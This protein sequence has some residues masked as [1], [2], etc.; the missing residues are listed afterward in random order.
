MCGI[1]GVI[2]FNREKISLN[3][4]NRFKDSLSHRGPDGEGT[5][6]NNIDCVAL[7]HRRLS[8]LDITESGK[9]PMSYDNERYWIVYNGE[10]YNFIELRKEL[11]S[12]GYAFKSNTDT[13]VILAAYIHWG[14]KCQYK[15]NGMWAFAI[16]DQVSKKIFI[17][18]DRFGVKPL[19]YS[20]SDKRIIFASELKAF[21]YLPKN[22]VPNFEL[23]SIASLGKSTNDEETFLENVNS[24]QPGGQIDLDIGG[25]YE[26]KKWWNTHDNLYSVS[27]NYESQIGTFRNLLRDAC[28]IRMRSDVPICSSLSGGMDSSS[29]VSMM[30]SIRK[31]Q[32]NDE[33]YNKNNHAA[34]ICDFIGSDDYEKYSERKYADEVVNFSNAEPFYINYDLKQVDQD[35][36]KKATFFQEMIG[37][38]A[39]GPWQIYKQMRKEKYYVSL[40]GH[41]GDEILAGYPTHI[42][43]AIEDA[44]S[45]N[46]DDYLKDILEIESYLTTVK[47]K[48]K[49]ISNLKLNYLAK[50]NFKYFDVIIKKIRDNKNKYWKKNSN[51]INVDNFQKIKF[52]KLDKKF[53]KFENFSILNNHLYHD[54]HKGV[55]TKVLHKFDRLSM[56]HGIEVRAPLLDYRIVQFLFSLPNT[57][58]ISNGYTKRIL[59]DSM[60]GMMPENVR[61]RKSKTGFDPMASWYENSV[62]NFI[63]DTIHS[64]SFLESNIW[65]GKLINKHYNKNKDIISSK[66]IFRF[67]QAHQLMTSFNDAKL[68]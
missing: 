65:D 46:S 37:E 4:I 43:S 24:L 55:L 38:P 20:L 1:T 13:E 59:R 50:K 39:V 52:K 5:Y 29:I 21:M 54:F 10:I 40:D 34:F 8:I 23:S 53:Q 31:D 35:T 57:S 60:K 49:N 63:L 56:A 41:G 9:Q 17:S 12:L 15:F 11:L 58:K 33:R 44:L 7:G 47:S 25:N 45:M 36:I 32:T 66:K 16:W 28:K 61:T 18:R 6:I 48:T 19:Y 30:S 51:Q 26:I 68:S 14:D 3:D 67:A 64:K 42:P 27:E 22:L 62:K 2:N